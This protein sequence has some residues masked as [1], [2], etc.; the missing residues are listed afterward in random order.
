[1]DPVLIQE[2]S[3]REHHTP[4][5]TVANLSSNR[6]DTTREI[7]KNPQGEYMKLNKETAEDKTRGVHQQCGPVGPTKLTEYK[8]KCINLY[9]PHDAFTT[10]LY[11]FS[12]AA[13]PTD[14]VV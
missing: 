5:I 12:A 6:W 10:F 3:I 1:M 8:K 13:Y 9:A 7:E 2:E 11:S 14:M 4:H